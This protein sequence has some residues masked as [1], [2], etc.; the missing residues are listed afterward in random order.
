[1]PIANIPLIPADVF[2]T[3]KSAF[4]QI[5]WV[6][7]LKTF[8]LLSE[9]HL[10]LVQ[11]RLSTIIEGMEIYDKNNKQ[12]GTIETIRLG[13]GSSKTSATDVETIEEA[14]KR[15]I[16]DAELPET[17]N[18]QLYE[19]GFLYIECGF[20]RDNA[21]VF[22]QQIEDIINDALHLNVDENELLKV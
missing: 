4:P 10:M 19:Q 9:R 21:I 8:H 1:M 11:Q 17:L 16:G 6:K 3:K 20:L 22:P 5:I 12:V 7:F 13:K 15:V 2:H 18:S 14:L